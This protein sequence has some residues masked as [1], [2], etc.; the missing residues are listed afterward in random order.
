MEGEMPHA[1]GIQKG[2]EKVKMVTL[3]APIKAF[4]PGPPPTKKDMALLVQ[5][6]S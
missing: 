1:K 3:V 2:P 5:L 4:S 6:P